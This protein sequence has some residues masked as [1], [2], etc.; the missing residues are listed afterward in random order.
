MTYAND[1]AIYPAAP[2]MQE[3]EY[4]L[5][6]RNLMA[7]GLLASVYRLHDEAD[8]V[9]SAVEMTLAD[10]TQYRMCRAVAQGM[11][12]NSKAAE[13]TLLLHIEANPND[14]SAK[15][16]LGVAMMLSGNPEWKHWIDNVLATSS[17]QAAREAASAVLTHLKA[18]VH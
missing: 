1:L 6:Y 3:A 17:D 12:G 18:L 5:V 4:P 16:A 2:V 15:V 9:S 14:D 11:G 13:E 7:V 8:I 10:T